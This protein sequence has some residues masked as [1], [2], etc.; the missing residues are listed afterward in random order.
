MEFWHSLLCT[1]TPALAAAAAAAAAATTAA[2]GA[3]TTDDGDDASDAS[4]CRLYSWI[5][6]KS[7]E[8]A[9]DADAG[10]Y[11]PTGGVPLKAPCR[12]CK[13]LPPPP[14]TP[15]EE[16]DADPDVEED[17]AADAEEEAAA[18]AA[19][20]LSRSEWCDADCELTLRSLVLWTNW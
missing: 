19:S 3:D 10:P 5:D 6:V 9:R 8:A 14:P 17:D 16:F 13:W 15:T 2:A 7:S 18:A 11:G 12:P 1:P 20:A 4:R